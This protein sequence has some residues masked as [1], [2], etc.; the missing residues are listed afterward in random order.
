MPITDEK[1]LSAFYKSSHILNLFRFVTDPET[2]GDNNRAERVIRKGV[3]I[4]KI[5]NGNRSKNGARF[6]EILLSVM[7]T[8][9]LQG[10]NPL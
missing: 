7:E 2:D 8:F 6:L 5:S 1:I 9:K 4:R 10:K 3:I